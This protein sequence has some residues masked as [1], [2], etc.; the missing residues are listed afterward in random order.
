MSTVKSP[1]CWFTTEEIMQMMVE[2]K[3]NLE[4]S[5]ANYMRQAD[6]KRMSKEF[7]EGDLVMAHLNKGRIPARSYS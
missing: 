4:Q 2:L 5:N 3:A 1:F 7:S 6:K